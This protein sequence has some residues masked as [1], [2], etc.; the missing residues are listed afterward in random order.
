MKKI[1]PLFLAIAVNAFVY[2]QPSEALD[3]RICAPVNAP[4]ESRWQNERYAITAKVI[5]NPDCA[6]VQMFICC[7]T[8]NTNDEGYAPEM[9]I[10]W[11]N[12]AVV[13]LNDENPAL[14]LRV[15]LCKASD[16]NCCTMNVCTTP[17]Q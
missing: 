4:S 17:P 6:H 8:S 7:L 11:D 3:I 9:N 10:P 1:V 15:N 12:E 13:T 5:P 16:D 2:A 14:Q